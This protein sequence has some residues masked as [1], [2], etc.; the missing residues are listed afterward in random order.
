M[1]YYRH[2]K[3]GKKK[4]K[5][6]EHLDIYR[7]LYEPEAISEEILFQNTPASTFRSKVR[8]ISKD[9]RGLFS[10]RAILNPFNYPLYSWG[11]V[12][13]KLLRWLVPY[14]LI[15]VFGLNLLLLGNQLYDL[16]MALQITFY[17]LAIAGYL[18]Q[19]KGKAPRGLGIPFSFCL[20]NLSALVGVAKFLMGRSSG[21][22]EPVRN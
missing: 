3:D 8:I 14:C 12:S 16:A 19:R 9:M 6:R 2:T 20:V 21:R 10:C 17:G 11:L 4:G 13:H 15:A 7:I 1:A 22:W 18:W 5:E